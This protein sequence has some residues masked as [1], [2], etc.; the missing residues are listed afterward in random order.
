MNYYTLLDEIKQYVTTYFHTHTNDKLIYHNLAHTENVVNAA[1]E[2]ANHY[3]LSDLDYF[4]VVTAAWFHD[5]GYYSDPSRHEEKGAEEAAAFLKRQGIDETTIQTVGNCIRATR[6]PQSPE[7]LLEKIVADADL[8]HLGTSRFTETNKTM[9]KEFMALHNMDISKDEWRAKT[10]RLLESHHYH[11]DYAQ[12]LL[13]DA[14]AKHLEKLKEKQAGKEPEIKAAPI[15]APAVKSKIKPLLPEENPLEKAKRKN[16]PERGI[17]TM[18]RITSGNH[19][20]LSDM[21]DSKAHIMISVNS[22]IISV[23]LS[24]LLKNL[25]QF[26]QYTI[27]AMLLL[28]V[29]LVTIV[30]AILATRPNIPKGTFTQT[31]INE[32]QVNLLFFG[33]FFKMS[34]DDYTG[35]MLHMMDDRDFLYRS[36]IKDIYSQ[37]VVLGTKYQRLRISYNVFMYGLIVSVIAFSIAAILTT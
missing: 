9:R 12:L 25:E 4:V 34:L 31:D 30:F 14:K 16:R 17:E 15:Q 23:L 5:I 1:V 22:I 37:G 27:P 19:Q 10:I 6:L 35:G 24:V 18:F 8:F 32:K 13:N 29:S 3:R 2:I 11:T 36:L 33:N 20:R 26:P 21:A 28:G 7:T